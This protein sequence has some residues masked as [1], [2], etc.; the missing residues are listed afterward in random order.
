MKRISALMLA[1]AFALTCAMGLVGCDTKSLNY[2]IENKPSVTGIVEEVYDHRIVMYSDTA[3]GYPYGS[4]WSI[5][6]DVENKDSYTG[7]NV[8][9]EIVV[10][11]DG[12]V[13]ETDPL[14]VGT[15]YAIT[16]KTPADK[17]ANDQPHPSAQVY[18]ASLS[19]ANWTED[20]GIYTGSLNLGKMQTDSLQHLPVY[21][22]DTA[23]DLEQFKITFGG[24]LTMDGGWDEVPSFND[25]TEK[26]D[27]AFF[28]ENTLV[29]VYIPVGNCT[30]RFGLGGIG[31]DEESFYI[32]VEETT[33]AEL[34]DM[35]M[36]GWFLTVAVADEAIA[37][38]TEFDAILTGQQAS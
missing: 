7:I 24:V 4:R 17:S 22:F 9:D 5:S 29:L 19:F 3:N 13:M 2:I 31:W 37:S 15:V 10:Y 14:K 1:L 11:H 18:D 36:A 38:C 20:S 26:Y 12:N 30:Q 21:K 27:E 25:T 6:L 16:L 35:A 32:H 33:G 28:D 34:V 23:E 8:G